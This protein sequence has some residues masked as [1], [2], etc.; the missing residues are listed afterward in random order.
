[1][2]YV[3]DTTLDNDND[4]LKM[5]K[6]NALVCESNTNANTSLDNV[7]LKGT[8][9][10]AKVGQGSNNI[11]SCTKPMHAVNIKTKRMHSKSFQDG[12]IC[13]FGNAI[14]TS[15]VANAD[16]FNIGVMHTRKDEGV[17]NVTKDPE[18]I[19]NNNTFSKSNG[20]NYD[21]KMSSSEVAL[22]KDFIFKRNTSRMSFNDKTHYPQESPKC[23]S[24]K[25]IIPKADVSVANK[26]TN[27][28]KSKSG[29]TTRNL[30]IIACKTNNA[31]SMCVNS[32]HIKGFDTNCIK[33]NANRSRKED[34]QATLHV[35]TD[36]RGVKLHT[37]NAALNIK[38][39]MHNCKKE[40]STTNNNTLKG[41]SIGYKSD[42]CTSEGDEIVSHTHMNP[43]KQ[44]SPNGSTLHTK[45]PLINECI[46]RRET[47]NGKDIVGL[48]VEKN[49]YFVFHIAKNEPVNFK[50]LVLKD[51][52]SDYGVAPIYLIDNGLE[53]KIIKPEKSNGYSSGSERNMSNE[54][55][56]PVNNC[57]I[58]DCRKLSNKEALQDLACTD[59]KTEIRNY[60]KCN[61]NS[62]IDDKKINVSSKC[63][64]TQALFSEGDG[65]RQSVLDGGDHSRIKSIDDLLHDINYSCDTINHTCNSIIEQHTGRVLEYKDLMK[66]KSS[67]EIWQKSF[68]NELGRLAQG[69]GK[70]ISGTNT[71]IFVEYKDIPKDRCKEITY[72]KLV[73]DYKPHKLE[74]CR[75]RL[76]VGGNNINYPHSV[77]T[78]TADLTTTKI[79]LNS[80]KSTVGGKFSTIDIGKFYLG[81][82]MDRP[83]F[84]VLPESLIPEEVV[85]EYNL[86]N[87]THKNKV[88]IKI[89][90]GM[91]GLPQA[92]MLA[93]RQ[94]KKSLSPFGYFPCKWTPGLWKHK[95]RPI[96]FTLIVDDFGVKYVV[97]VHFDH[98]KYTLQSLYPTITIDTKGELY[99]GLNLKWNYSAN[100]VDVSMPKY[101]E[102]VLHK[103]QHVKP[104][105]AQHSPHKW[106]RAIYGRSQQEPIP[107][108]NSKP[109]SPQKSKNVQQIIGSLLY[110]AR[111]VDPTIL[112]ALG[113]ISQQ[114]S[115]P[116]ENTWLAVKQLLDY[117]GTYPDA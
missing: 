8:L 43:R 11:Y 2:N 63:N 12:S 31:N 23:E 26:F 78:E 82:K 36:R 4:K 41:K 59:I 80:V 91:Y 44:T 40:D 17:I 50:H 102:K 20:V 52:T 75:T 103:F 73:V 67:K 72:G 62:G 54:I 105:K 7:M 9:V 65:L 108:D 6:S 88:Y 116:T 34:N 25:S 86:D 46:I 81:T 1:M 95:W 38:S 114:Q 74:K 35:N 79:L 84:M 56:M 48:Y 3:Y 93:N 55:N 49:N 28:E 30:C 22:R 115:A 60:H 89:I 5:T 61:A 53:H 87:I 97:K 32:S 96:A 16:R 83:E 111:A 98:L 70:I 66:D 90:K 92:G 15:D 42:N 57:Q 37:I 39:H 58:K 99:C 27:T 94:L 14:K 64:D 112:V 33:G 29:P 21:G 45:T 101:I 85:N 104:T 106:H 69:I 109:L 47:S 113:S 107:D 51:E 117:C 110:Y 77:R 76:T 13:G 24:T 19:T 68:S 71:I 18:I 100:Y 10:N